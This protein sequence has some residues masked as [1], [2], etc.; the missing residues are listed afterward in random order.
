MHGLG[1]DFVVI[2]ATVKSPGLTPEL[3]RNMSDRRRGIGFDQLLLIESCSGAADFIY[4]IFNADGSEVSQCGNGARCVARF[5]HD[6][7]LSDAEWVVLATHSDKL[8]VSLQTDDCAI[9]EMPQPKWL[10][11][12]IPFVADSEASLYKIEISGLEL[13][14][15]VVN[16]G[17]PHLICQVPDLCSSP[18]EQIAADLAVHPRFKDG[19]NVSFVQIAD[20][21]NIQLRVYERGAGETQAC[22]SAA[23]AAVVVGHRWGRLDTKVAVRQPGGILEVHCLDSDHRWLLSGPIASVYSGVWSE[24]ELSLA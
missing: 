11:A 3:I 12:D 21:N 13:E 8:R 15:G 20:K 4:R 10:P 1:N 2:D 14:V 7:G 6:Q 22:G 18:F 19:V 17:N 24:K 16:V 9:V 5:L 23:F